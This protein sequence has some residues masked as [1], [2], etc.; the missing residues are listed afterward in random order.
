MN[1][2]KSIFRLTSRNSSR[3]TDSHSHTA[4]GIYTRRL[5]QLNLIYQASSNNT[6]PSGSHERFRTLNYGA[7]LSQL[8]AQ[9]NAHPWRVDNLITSSA[10]VNMTGTGNYGKNSSF[11]N[12]LQQNNIER[13]R[14]VIS[15]DF[16]EECMRVILW[17]WLPVVVLSFTAKLKENCVLLLRLPNTLLF[18]AF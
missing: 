14:F 13:N 18:V 15:T 8:L 12:I 3:N 10:Y 5:V 7:R 1:C 16:D 11:R 4:N 9:K 6:Y 17:K 2:I